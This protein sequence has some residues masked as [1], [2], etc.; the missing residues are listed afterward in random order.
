VIEPDQATRT[1]YE[2]WATLAGYDIALA[3]DGREGLTKA[4]MHPPALVVLEL[5]LPLIDGV[6]LCEILR[7]DRSTTRTPILVVTGETRA[8]ELQRI[9]D[10]GVDEVLLKP[11]PVDVLTRAVEQLVAATHETC[12]GSW[13][14]ASQRT[15]WSASLPGVARPATAV[16]RARRELTTTPP[17]VA[18]ALTCPTC[19]RALTYC[20][21]Q[22]G[23]V[24]DR[25]SEQWDYF[26]CP[27]CGA[28]Q[29]RQRTRKV[30]KL[31]AVEE[32]WLQR[33]RPSVA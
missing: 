26:S 21:S 5:R 24:S 15:G 3:A 18:P 12:R 16:A 28:F 9:R 13:P 32:R 14:G 30:R 31:D 1:M 7:R 20:F 4:L 6:A 23:G 2:R 33:Q 17:L 10:V 25:F 29:Y 19:D 8:A 27:S 22:M 11:V